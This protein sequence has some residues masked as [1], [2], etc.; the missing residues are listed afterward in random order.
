ML[1][2]LCRYSSAI[3]D[4]RR[5]GGAAEITSLSVDGIEGIYTSQ[6][7]PEASVSLHLS[8]ICTYAT[9]GFQSLQ[10]KKLWIDRLQ[11]DK[12]ALEGSALPTPSPKPPKTLSISYPF[13]SS[14]ILQEQVAALHLNASC[15]SR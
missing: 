7:S 12:K 5:L 1:R 2:P 9:R 3:T 11:R 13:S 8:D 15:C 14:P 10:T 6:A 4:L